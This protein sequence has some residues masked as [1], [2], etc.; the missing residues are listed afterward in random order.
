ML[1][2]ALN[3]T[4]MKIDISNGDKFGNLTVIKENSKVI[5]INKA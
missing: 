4:I 3:Y 1:Y 5:T 2:I